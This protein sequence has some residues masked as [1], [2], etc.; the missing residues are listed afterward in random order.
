[1]KFHSLMRPSAPGVSSVPPIILILSLGLALRL[2]PPVLTIHHPWDSQTWWDVFVD[3]NSQPDPY[4]ALAQPYETLRDLSF[5]ARAS[6]EGMY[7]EY[8]AYPP[9]MLYVF[10]PLA[11]LYGLIDPSAHYLFARPGSFVTMAIPPAF[12]LLVKLPVIVADLLIAVIL[13]RSAGARWALLYL[14]NPYVLLASNWMFDGVMVLFL[15]LALRFAEKGHGAASGASM[16]VA[17]SVKYMPAFL[18]PAFGTYFLRKSPVQWRTVGSFALTLLVLLILINGPFLEGLRFALEFQ[19]QRYGGGMNWQA[20]WHAWALSNPDTRGMFL[21]TSGYIGTL[22]LPLGILWASVYLARKQLSL[23]DLCLVLSATYLATTKLVNEVYLL[24]LLPLL[25]VSHARRPTELKSAAY[26]LGSLI[27]ICWA[28]INVPAQ[29]FLVSVSMNQ[30][31]ITGD[32]AKSLFA[33]HREAVGQTLTVA[34]AVGG[35]LATC[36]FLALALRIAREESQ[37]NAE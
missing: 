37:R 28:A 22:T 36:A 17:I 3:L 14:V 20:V 27:P 34:I 9:A 21:F 11:K 8:W 13:Y 4:R 19:G 24:P 6:R 35:F 23:V 33:A 26:W 12:S 29:G 32:V 5:A 18:L 15:L 2:L 10:Y 7:Y 16:A 31:M 30:G 1:M 25:S